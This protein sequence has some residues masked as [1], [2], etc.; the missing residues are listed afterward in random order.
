MDPV[1]T[2]QLGK[3]MIHLEKV[4]SVGYF[5]NSTMIFMFTSNC[6]MFMVCFLVLLVISGAGVLY[7]RDVQ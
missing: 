7:D 6:E 1:A 4:E 3:E 5:L 2:V